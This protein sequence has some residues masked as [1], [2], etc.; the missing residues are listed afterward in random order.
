MNITKTDMKLFEDCDDVDQ[1]V[2]L[3]QN[4]A[5]MKKRAIMK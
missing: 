2:Y 3:L 4:L 5:E 1:F